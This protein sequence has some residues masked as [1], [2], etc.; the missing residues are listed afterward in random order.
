LSSAEE[1]EVP[2]ERSTFLGAFDYIGPQMPVALHIF[3]AYKCDHEG[4]GF[5]NAFG[6]QAVF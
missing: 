3:T 5:A 6:I 4:K 2:E 1:S